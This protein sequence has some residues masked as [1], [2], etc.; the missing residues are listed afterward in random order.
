MTLVSYSNN[1]VRQRALQDLHT[2]AQLDPQNG[3]LILQHPKFHFWLLE[4]LMP[5][6]D[7][8]KSQTVLS[9]SSRAVYDMGCKLHTLLLKNACLDPEEVGFKRTNL[10]VRW[11]AFVEQRFVKRIS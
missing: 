9:D 7:F 3:H 5:Y 11:P 4:L 6:Q 2:L 10:L 1:L 8:S